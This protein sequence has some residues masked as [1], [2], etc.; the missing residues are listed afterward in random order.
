MK[1]RRSPRELRDRAWQ[2]YRNLALLARPPGASAK[3]ATPS[4]LAIFPDPVGVARDLRNGD[5]AREV[6]ETA[7]Q[8]LAH[9]FPLLGVT[10]DTGP[11]IAWRRDYL[12][13]KETA[14]DYFRLVPY[15]DATRAGDHKLIWELNRHQHLVLLAQAFLFSEDGRYLEEIKRQLE[16]WMLANPF[17]RGINWASALEVAFRSLSWMWV[18]HFVGD[19]FEPLFRDRFLHVLELHGRHLEVNLSFYFSPNTHLLGEAVALHALG[20]LFPEFARSGE[21]RDLGG[22]VVREQREKQVRP[23]GAHFEQSTY[24]HVYALDMF[25]FFELLDG[26]SIHTQPLAEV[27]HALMGPA[28]RLAFFGD[29]DGGRFFHPFG[30]RDEFGRASLA[31]CGI[32]SDD[33]DLHAMAA[34][35]ITE[36]QMEPRGWRSR[37][38][39]DSG[40]AL[41][42][43]GP[44]QCV[45]DAGQFGP[46]GSGH[47][48]SDTL[49]FT[50]RLADEDILI[51]SGTYT[52]V[53]DPVARDWFRG[54]AAHNT[55]RIDG[56]DQAIPA[57]PFRWT[58][59]PAVRILEWRSDMQEDCLAAECC[60]GGFTHK[61]T[62]VFRKPGRLLVTDEITGPVGEHLIEQF[63]HLGSEAARA[64]LQIDPTMECQPFTGLA[65]TVLL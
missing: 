33:C 42:S 14:C 16:S 49:S 34:W 62:F 11:Q 54:S 25:R 65:S 36:N 32:G 63:W 41:M 55:I 6:L 47:S 19:R 5:F 56:R 12:S 1:L 28:R 50:V 52:Y 27:L 23:D 15:L 57:G 43:H 53:S 9:R 2:E 8:I 46:W 31:A 35:W 26:R 59:Q 48:H 17:Q 10:I 21:W 3:V 29:D 18:Y 51:D 24:Y 7:D 58:N 37:L 44:V 61:R 4:P 39:A 40:L 60:Y 22:R 13:G 30:R 45:I 64:R 38:F 20:V